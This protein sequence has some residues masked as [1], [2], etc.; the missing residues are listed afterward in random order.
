M[1]ANR[2]PPARPRGVS[3]PRP[4]PKAKP[5]GSVKFGKIQRVDP[6]KER[7]RRRNARTRKQMRTA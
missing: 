3:A 1:S 6:E 2:K 7:Q 5:K 4:K